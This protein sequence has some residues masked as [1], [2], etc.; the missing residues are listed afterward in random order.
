MEEKKIEKKN[1][2]SLE[3][4]TILITGASSG[5][6]RATAI[7]CAKM[8]ARLIITARNEERLGETFKS[9]SG[10]AHAMFTADLSTDEGISEVLDAVSAEK[11]SGAVLNAGISRP[12]PVQFVN[13]KKMTE[14]FPTNLESPILLFSAL[15]KRKILDRGSAAVFTSSINGVMGGGTA[16][17][18][19][20]A[21]K[22]GLSG[23]VKSACLDVAP[24]GIRVNCVCP[25]MIETAIFADSAIT[26]EQLAENA[27]GYP[28]RR[29]GRAEE[30]AWAIIYLLS[31]AASFVTGTNLVIDGGISCKI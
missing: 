21:S 13:R 16:E 19:Y 8:G 20:A 15:V 5:I 12:L 27:R 2:F 17:S 26:A 31:D 24:K 14:I 3:G 29:H 7:E 28:M 6:G 10:N 1:Q 11:L 23:F 4:K 22:A 30:V 9:L 25:G 18:L